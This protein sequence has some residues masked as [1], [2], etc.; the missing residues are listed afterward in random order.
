MQQVK[1]YGHGS[2]EWFQSYLSDR[3]QTVQVND[4]YSNIESIPCGV[5]QGS[6]LG[7]FLFLCYVND[8]SIISYCSMQMIVQV[9]FLIKKSMLSRISWEK[10]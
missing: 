5:P 3:T 10:S 9:Y 6:I 7:P 4:A 8:M 2:V 1:G